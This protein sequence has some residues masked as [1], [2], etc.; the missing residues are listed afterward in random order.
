STA[1]ATVDVARP[2]ITNVV[3]KDITNAY[4]RVTW[5]TDEPSTSKVYYG[6]TPSLGTVVEV[7][8]LMINHEVE[9]YGLSTDTLYYFDVESSDMFGHTTR[10]DN[11]GLHYTFRT[12]EKAGILVV[13]GDATFDREEHYRDALDAN[14]W[15]YNEW[16]AENQGDPPLATLQEYNVIMWQTGY[17]QYPPFS[18]DQRI[19]ITEYLDSGGRLF[20]SSHDVAWAFGDSSISGWYSVEK[21]SWMRGTLKARYQVDPRTYSKNMGVIGNPISGAYGSG[22]PYYPHRAGG[23]GDEVYL[24]NA[25][26]ISLPVWNTGG[27]INY[28]PGIIDPDAT[29][30]NAMQWI[31]SFPN[32]T[33]GTGVWGGMVSKVVVFYFEFTRINAATDND[34]ARADILNKVIIWLLDDH[35]HPDVQ[36]SAPNG[37]ETFTTS[38]VTISWTA[39][40]FG[41][42]IDNQSVYYSGNAGQSWIWVADVGPTA[43]SY[44]WDISTLP[45]GN[46]Y[47]VK[48]KVCDDGIP[49]LCGSDTSDSTFTIM[50]SGGDLEGP[51]T[52]PGSVKIS[53]NYVNSGSTVWFNATVDDSNRGNSMINKA[54][55]FIQCTEPDVSQYGTGTDMVASDGSFDTPVEDVT[56][57]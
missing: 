27:T 20:V 36:V 31:S 33:A 4:A 43:T 29:D 14:G 13:Y 51:I 11:G 2:V 17:E 52:I 8:A 40:T 42:G 28:G 49:S 54:E 34:P 5:D 44:N 26:G 57:T 47:M 19:R 38:P 46:K 37:G 3:V 50:K 1:T 56:W 10:D 45:N 55:Y 15:P 41:T 24:E 53:P 32:G 7:T 22:V 39:T 48:V 35:D 9:I 25:G 23:A 6:E 21:D 18:D 12:R 30:Y 16:Y